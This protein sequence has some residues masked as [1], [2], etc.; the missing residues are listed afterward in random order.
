MMPH[1]R[2]PVLNGGQIYAMI[3]NGARISY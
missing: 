3:A 1:Q 2:Y